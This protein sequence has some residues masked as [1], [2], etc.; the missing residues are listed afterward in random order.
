MSL[1]VC[2]DGSVKVLQQ[3]KTYL[4][5]LKIRLFKNDWNPG[6]AD[7]VAD[8]TE[9]NFDGY[10]AKD[11]DQFGDAFLNGDNKAESDDIVRTWTC[12]GNV[13][14]NTIYGYYI[15][16]PAGDLIWAERNPAGGFVVNANGITYS[17]LPRITL[18]HD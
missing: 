7:D 9:A 1:V 3:L 17:V 11:V 4:R 16:N 15:T 18:T 14:P 12:T 13:T 5:T 10:A 2:F 6:P 8:Y